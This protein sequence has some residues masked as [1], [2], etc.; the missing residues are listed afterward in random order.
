MG[1]SFSAARLDM[2]EIA[3]KRPAAILVELAGGKSRRTASALRFF[4]IDYI[5]KPLLERKDLI[6]PAGT[7]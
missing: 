2:R 5:F 4:N 1:S 7:T 6:P 3:R